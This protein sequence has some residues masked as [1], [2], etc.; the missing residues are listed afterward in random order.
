M[1]NGSFDENSEHF[2]K[3]ILPWIIL[4][5]LICVAVALRK[6]CKK[7]GECCPGKNSELEE[8]LTTTQPTEPMLV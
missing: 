4:G 8:K 6:H 3:Y 1:T 7:C 2:L 5:I